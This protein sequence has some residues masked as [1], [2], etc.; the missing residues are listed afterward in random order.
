MRV[1]Q[2]TGCQVL[3]SCLAR[4]RL[5]ALRYSQVLRY[6]SLIAM[7]LS[8]VAQASPVSKQKRDAKSLDLPDDEEI[9]VHGLT[10]ICRHPM[11][12]SV[13]LFSL[14]FTLAPS[15][16]RDRAWQE[17]DLVYLCDVLFWG[18]HCVVSLSAIILDERMMRRDPAGVYD[19]L[20]RE[21]S[22]LPRVDRIFSMSMMEMQN[23]TL[24]IVWSFIA[25]GFLY[26][27]PFSGF[28]QS[29]CGAVD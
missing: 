18:A 5:Q 29:G 19:K 2:F 1:A 28:S 25:V 23:L 3:A 11:L 15:A 26:M 17:G 22:V 6:Q 21:S 8:G 9:R 12:L 13:F 27:S 4:R 7:L 24:C 14:S 20:L 16:I 10:R